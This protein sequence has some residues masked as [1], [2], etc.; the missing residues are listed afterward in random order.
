M[1]ADGRTDMTTLVVAFRKFADATNFVAI[2]ER[3][4]TLHGKV[5]SVH[6]MNTFTWS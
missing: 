2:S 5:V 3:C 6:A 4:A 1:R